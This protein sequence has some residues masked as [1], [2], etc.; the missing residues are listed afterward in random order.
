MILFEYLPQICKSALH[1]LFA[2]EVV[3]AD[4]GPDELW[5]H[6]GGHFPCFPKHEFALV[7]GLSFKPT[8]FNPS[9][10]ANPPGDGLF[11]PHYRGQ[12]VKMDDLLSDFTKG[13]FCGSPADALKIL[14]IYVVIRGHTGI[15]EYLWGS[16][17]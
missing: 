1:Y 14:L 15:G 13:V 3:K 11:F 17:F 5:Y 8:T 10:K 9:V 16:C 12:R 4:A 7:T 2:H 6:V